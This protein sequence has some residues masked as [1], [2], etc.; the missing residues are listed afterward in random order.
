MELELAG[1]TA[2]ITGGSKGI[3]RACAESLAAEGLHL[4][5]AARGKEALAETKDKILRNHQVSIETHALDLSDS[6]AQQE[7]SG[8]CPDIDILVNN[9]GAIPGGTVASID[10]G[11]WREA[12][13]LKVFGYINLCRIFH[14][15]MASRGQGVIVNVIGLAGEAFN[16]GYIAGSTGNAGLM[17]FT[18]ALGST[19]LDDGVRVVGINPGLVETG[20][21][22]TLMEQR[23]EAEF[24]DKSRWRDLTTNLPAG[25]AA[26]PEEVANLVTFLASERAAYTTGVIYSIDG[27]VAARHGL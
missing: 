7:L 16:A 15:R 19:S 6:E 18:R 8:R 20:R 12:W 10:E 5:L 21:M 25:R 23:A 24:G 2:L 14:A 11:R 22:V 3:G 1:R 9:A 17:A 13:D 27:G 4:H 26:K